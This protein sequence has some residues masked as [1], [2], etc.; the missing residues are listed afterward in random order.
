MYSF[1]LHILVTDNF[2]ICRMR[3]I[4]WTTQFPLCGRIL[5][6]AAIL[7]SLKLS[8]SVRSLVQTMPGPCCAHLFSLHRCQTKMDDGDG[9]NDSNHEIDNGSNHEIDSSHNIR[10]FPFP[11][12]VKIALV[13]KL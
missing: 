12:G 11:K 5:L 10:R 6:S 2:F 8:T 1:K 4:V 9:D 13:P 7:H 3:R